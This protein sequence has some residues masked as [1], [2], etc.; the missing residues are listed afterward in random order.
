[1]P[2]NPR[3]RKLGQDF[4]ALCIANGEVCEANRDGKKCDRVPEYRCDIGPIY[5][6]AGT[7]GTINFTRDLCRVHAREFAKPL[8]L[9]LTGKQ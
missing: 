8:G 3:I 1:M 5:E 6:N 2:T 4:I 9:R 7:N